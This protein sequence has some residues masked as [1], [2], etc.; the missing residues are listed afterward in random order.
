[1]VRKAQRAALAG[2]KDD[3]GQHV[4]L[5]AGDLR[6]H[7]LGQLLRHVDDGVALLRQT[8]QGFPRRLC[9]IGEE[10][11]QPQGPKAQDAVAVTQYSDL[12]HMCHAAFPVWRRR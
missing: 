9:V 3:S 12:I 7:A 4:I 11:V 8:V 10:H 1:M 5:I 6:R 2:N